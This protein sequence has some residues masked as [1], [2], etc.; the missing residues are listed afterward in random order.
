MATAGRPSGAGSAQSGIMS[1]GRDG[2][3]AA[4]RQ[5][6]TDAKEWR[7]VATPLTGSAALAITGGAFWPGDITAGAGPSRPH[8]AMPIGLAAPTAA[9]F[10]TASGSGLAWPVSHGLA[11]FAQA[12]LSTWL[13]LE[14]Q[15]IDIVMF[16]K[17]SRSGRPKSG[18]KAS[19]PCDP[20]PVPAP[21]Y[22]RAR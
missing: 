11:G 9:L 17:V 22:V 19:S 15:V 13:I 7:P 21:V 3:S 12:N 10:G 18:P 14:N 20:L 5:A 16:R 6:C 2:M 8:P 1:P 4:R